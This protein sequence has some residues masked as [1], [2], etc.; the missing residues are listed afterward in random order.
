MLWGCRTL[1][2]VKTPALMLQE[3][4]LTP[5][6]IQAQALQRRECCRDQC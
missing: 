5:G 6:Y 3:L 2:K 4:K 1:S